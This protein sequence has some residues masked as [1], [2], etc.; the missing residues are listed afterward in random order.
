M[1]ANNKVLSFQASKLEGVFSSL[2]SEPKLVS[3]QRSLGQI[4]SDIKVTRLL[5][6]GFGVISQLDFG[7]V[8]SFFVYVLEN[9]VISPMITLVHVLH[10]GEHLDEGWVLG[11]LGKVWRVCDKD[12]REELV[13][14]LGVGG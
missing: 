4:I 1:K 11:L 8:Q 10:W 6:F 9:Q 7:Y 3:K 5:A 13:L 14:S 2:I 12:Q